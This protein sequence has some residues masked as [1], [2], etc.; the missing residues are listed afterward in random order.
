MPNTIPLN[1]NDLHL[2]RDLLSFDPLSK[3][4]KVIHTSG[5]IPPRTLGACGIYEDNHFYIFGGQHGD[6]D[7]NAFALE[8]NNCQ[9]YCL[10]LPTMEWKLLDSSKESKTSPQPCEK[11]LMTYNGGFLYVFGGYC[12]VP[13]AYSKPFHFALDPNAA[14]DW[15]R[16]WSSNLHRFNAKKK[17]WE[18]ILVQPSNLKITSRAGHAGDKTSAGD[19]WVIFGGNGHQSKLNDVL[20]FDFKTGSWTI[21]H[22]GFPFDYSKF[23]WTGSV[24]T[25]EGEL[26]PEPRSGHSFTRIG[27]TDQ[28]FL[29]GGISMLQQPLNDAWILTLCDNFVSWKQIH[30]PYDFAVARCLHA[31]VWIEH[32]ILIHSGC[33]QEFYN[34]NLH[35]NDHPEDILTF[36]LG[37]KSL[38]LTCVEL[39]EKLGINSKELPKNISFLFLARKI[40]SENS[41]LNHA[42]RPNREKEQLFVRSVLHA[43]L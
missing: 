40:Y 13:Q 23:D 14:Y 6:P 26:I 11:S 21:A 36:D 12:E 30:L 39:I 9:I 4:W 18:F 5:D 28:F 32:E 22:P 20:I 31:S 27:Q 17:T 43:G 7:E 42:L 34:N 29:Y 1:G 19:R 35:L 10:N 8:G 33:T 25:S 3:V 16:G 38:F 41:K 2:S 37:V 24:T 15:P